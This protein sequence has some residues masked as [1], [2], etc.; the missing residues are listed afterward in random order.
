MCGVSTA[1][2][3]KRF[4]YYMW[5]SQTIDGVAATL[6]TRPDDFKLRRDSIQSK[7][8]LLGLALFVVVYA[9]PPRYAP[10]SPGSVPR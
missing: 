9:L 7:H 10:M 2:I 1:T 8:L 4:T 6:R 3:I 5:L